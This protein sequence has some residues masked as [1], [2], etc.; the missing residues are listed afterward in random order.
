MTIRENVLIGALFGKKSASHNMSEY[1]TEVDRWIDFVKLRCE[2]D[3][4][5][6]SLNTA[7]QKR[8]NLAKALAA[9]PKLLILDE[10]MAG[11]NSK[12]IEE[13]MS[14]IEEINKEGVT[15]LFIEHV[16]KAVMGISHRILVLHHGSKIAEGSPEEI[17]ND[18]S[19]IKAYLGV[20]YEK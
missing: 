2:K 4:S 13:M 8:V 9:H 7:D 14:L 10:V 5:I 18:E 19:V 1:I 3:C 11:L 20:R 15:V 6:S 16:M 17:V 12:E